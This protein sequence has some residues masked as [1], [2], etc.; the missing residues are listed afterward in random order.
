MRRVTDRHSMQPKNTQNKAQPTL[1]TY[2]TLVKAKN[3]KEPK[4]LKAHKSTVFNKKNNAG[5][6]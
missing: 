5:Y 6:P 4:N 3:V 1:K 2:S